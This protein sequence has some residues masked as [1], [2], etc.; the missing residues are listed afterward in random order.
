MTE[1]KDSILAVRGLKVDFS[2]PDGTVEA[3]KGIDLDVRS[4]ETLAVVGESG[5]G[6]SQ[7]M[8]GIMGLLCQERDGDGFGALS[9]PG[10]RGP[11]TEGTEPVRGSKITMIFQ[12]AD[13]LPLDR[14]HDR[15]P[16]RRADRPSPGRQLQEERRRVSSSWS[17]S[18]SRTGAGASTAIRTSFPAAAPARHDRHGAANEPDILIADE[19]TT[20]LDV[21]IQAQSS[22]CSNRCKGASAWRSF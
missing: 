15:P 8:M 13:E 22:I 21:T 7:T 12:E 9:R 10:T 2:T 20:A 4:G 1:T 11:C 14:L 17:S 19:P 18:D 5:S 3:V 6:K 16:D